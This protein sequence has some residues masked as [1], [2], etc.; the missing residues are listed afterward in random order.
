MTAF[1]KAHLK[2]NYKKKEITKKLLIQIVRMNKKNRKGFKRG[3]KKERNCIKI[4]MLIRISAHNHAKTI[5][6][7]TVI[8]ILTVLKS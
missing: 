1:K 6:Q 7:K 3:H 2:T 8:K 4:I 5:I